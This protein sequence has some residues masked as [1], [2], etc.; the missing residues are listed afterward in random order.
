M[1]GFAWQVQ[2]FTKR[3]GATILSCIGGVGAIATTIMAVKAT[4]K[5]IKQIEAAEKEKGDK[6]TKMEMVTVTGK[7]YIPTVLVGVGT[8]TCIFGANALNQKQQASLVSAY[9]LIDNSYKRY[10][11]KLVELYGK[12]MHDKIM[13]EIVI[14]EARERGIRANCFGSTC[15]LTGEDACGDAV[16]FYDEYA[17]RYFE[18]TIEQVMA[19]EY[20]LNRNFTLR[21]YTI[22]NEFYDFLG[23]DP[24]EHGDKVGWTPED[25]LYW[26]DFNHHKVIMDDGLECYIIETPWGPSA[27]FMEYYYS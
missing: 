6:L 5:A 10:K 16:L 23:L 22:L 26:I 14:E 1:N 7:T 20:H 17:D 21:G 18:S 27:E 8:L 12:E 15:M 19:A 2:R 11:N 3:H 4:P 25:G 13:D 9:T 24:T